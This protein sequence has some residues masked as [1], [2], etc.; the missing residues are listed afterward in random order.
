MVVAC[1]PL[2][3]GREAQIIRYIADG[4]TN[5]EIGY[6]LG[7]SEEMAKTHVR[8]IFRKLNA[9]GRANAVILAI[10]NHYLSAG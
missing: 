7:I 4:N 5:R 8:T 10:R 9:N 6:I 3:T 1:K 2:L